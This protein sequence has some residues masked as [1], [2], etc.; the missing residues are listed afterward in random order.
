MEGPT[1]LQLAKYYEQM[2]D[3]PKAALCYLK[4]FRGGESFENDDLFNAAVVF[5]LLDDVNYDNVGLV[6]DYVKSQC[7]E[8]ANEFLNAVQGEKVNDLL[9]VNFWK[10][11][12]D[13]LN[14]GI[15]EIIIPDE[16]FL[17]GAISAAV[18]INNGVLDE[19]INVQHIMHKAASMNSERGRYILSVLEK[20]GKSIRQQS[21]TNRC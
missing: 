13:L 16:Y 2:S 8:I 4:A 18:Y 10:S 14:G 21:K 15:D 12:I 7:Y 11:Y 17:S 1:N 19:E 5:I 6:P 9:D 20:Y 3:G